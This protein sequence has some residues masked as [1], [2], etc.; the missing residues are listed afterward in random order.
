[1]FVTL[2][3]K[4]CNKIDF[5]DI[6]D[7]FFSTCVNLLPASDNNDNR[8]LVGF[9]VIEFYFRQKAPAKTAIHF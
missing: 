9:Q 6:D 5:T 1:M 2:D 8:L 7:S 3:G 4:N